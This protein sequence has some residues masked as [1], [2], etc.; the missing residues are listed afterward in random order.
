MAERLANATLK[1]RA[2]TVWLPFDFKVDRLQNADVQTV[3]VDANSRKEI[4]G[5]MK[6]G[7]FNLSKNGTSLRDPRRIRR[8]A[9]FDAATLSFYPQLLF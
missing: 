6:L 1:S 2:P 4:C 9:Y 7:D 3:A 5:T 8:S